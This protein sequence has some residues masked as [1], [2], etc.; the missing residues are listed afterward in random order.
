MG[1]LEE[2]LD[3]T[4]DREHSLV[5]RAGKQANGKPVLV[6]NE[7]LMGLNAGFLKEAKRDMHLNF[8]KV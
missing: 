4:F 7:N 5:F 6:K 3:K 8:E 2:C 1:K